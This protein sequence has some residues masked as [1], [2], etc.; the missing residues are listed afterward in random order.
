MS[1]FYERIN[2]LSQKR[3]VLL[4]MELQSRL[5][6]LESGPAA[7]TAGGHDIAVIG[8]GCRFPGGANSPETFWQLLQEGRDAVTEIPR[9]RWDIDAYYD[10]DVEAEGK[11][12]TRWGGFMND[13]DQFDPALFGIT[14]RE[15][16]TMDPQQRIVLEV[17]WEALERAGYA[18][19]KL[20][21]SSTG[22]FIG[23][24]NG[25]YGH[26]LMTTELET[27][28]MYMATGAAHSVI[29]GRVAYVL[30]LQ[31]PA[32]SVDTACSSSLVA[33]HYAIK[34]LRTGDCRMALAGGVNAIL[35]PDTTV[36]LS[37]AKMM[38]TEGRCKAFAADADGFVR[39]EGCGI[40]VLKRLKDAEADGDPILAVIRGTAINQDG[41][42]NGLTAPNG[43]SQVAVVRA[44]LADAG[45]Q[46]AEVGYV[47][48]HGTGT[49]LGDPIEAQALGA[50]Y[51]AGHTREN[52]LMIGSVK[53]N[54]GHMESAAGVGG[55]MKLILA[56]QYGEIPPHLHLRE[57]SPHIAWDELPITIPTTRSAWHGRR[58][59]AVSSFGFS[60]TNVHIIAEAYTPTPSPLRGALSGKEQH[61]L[62][63]SA[64]TATA[65]RAL[66]GRYANFL[67]Q[68]P[69]DAF[70][71]VAY[72]ANTTRASLSQRLALVAA[73]SAQARQKLESY[74][75]DPQGGEV[76]TAAQP[77]ARP[78]EVA[79][80]FTGHG[81][82]FAGMGRKLYETQPA[83]R[84]VIDR[85]SALAADM[86]PRPLIEA[87]YPPA[88]E[89]NHLLDT[90]TYGQ[91]VIFALQ[92]ALA[93]LWR[94]WGIQPA[95]VTGHSLGEYAAA[96]AAGILSLEDG[97]KLVCTRGRL[98]DNLPQSG[99]MAS[100]F[101]TEEEVQAIIQPRAGEVSIAVIN[102]PTNIVISGVP[103][104]VEAALAA[105]EAQGIKTR[106]LAIAAGAHSPLVE[107]MRAEFMRV[108]STVAFHAPR[109]D[110]VSCT[111]GQPVTAAEV[112]TPEYWWRH[113]R[114]PVQF[115]RVMQTLQAR[116]LAVFVEIGPHPVLLSIGQRVLPS[117]YG[118]WIPSLREKTDDTLQMLEALGML[119][120]AG[121]NIHWPGVYATTARSTLLLPTYAFD[122]QRYWFTA[123]ARPAG[124]GAAGMGTIAPL[125]GARIQSPVLDD[126][127][128]ETQLSATWPA[129]LDH[130][131]IFGTSI[132][133][134]PAYIEMATRAAE[135]FFGAGYYRVSNLAI[136]EAMILPEDGLRTAQ[137]ILTPEGESGARFKIVSQEPGGQWRTHATGEVARQPA[138]MPTQDDPSANLRQVEAARARCAE[139][140]D[141]ET[142]YANV[143]TLG[144][145]FGESFRGLRHIWRRD[146]EAVGRVELPA[147]L[148]GDPKNYRFHPALLDACFHLIGAP[149]PGGK[150]D[151]AFLL[152]GLEHFRLYRT[153]PTVLWNHTVLANAGEQAGETFTGDV[154]LYAEDGALVAEALGLQ[155]KRAS[156]ELL[157]RAV[158]PRFDEWLYRV[159]WQPRP[160]PLGQSKR[161]PAAW[162]LIGGD[163]LADA[164]MVQLQQAGENVTR[165]A[166]G[167]TPPTGAD[168]LYLAGVEA[169]EDD[170]LERSV[171][172]CAGLLD[173]A[174][175]EQTGRLWAAT[176]G[177]QPVSGAPAQPA[178]AALW[179]LGRVIA[180][181]LP[182]AW[183]GLI[184]LDPAQPPAE[185]ARLLVEEIRAGDSEDQVAYRAGQRSVARLARAARPSK[186]AYVFQPDAAYLITGGLG[187]IGMAIAR[188][189]ADHGARHIVLIGRHG[190]P[191]R[192][193]WDSLPAG[194]QQA[195][196]AATIRAIE[197][198]SGASLEALAVDASDPSALNALLASFGS[199]RP[200]LKGI[201]HAAAVLGN[202]GVNELSA[203][204]L[205]AMFTPKV[206]GAVNL[207]AAARGLDLDFL[208]L[209]SSTTALWGS[210]QMGHYA[211]ANTFL[212]SYA[213][214]LR[215]E[216][217]PALSINWGT[218]E[219]MRVASQADQQRVA[220]FGLEQMPVE[221]AM[222]ALSALIPSGEAQMT[223]AAVDW[224][225][226]KTAYEARRAR[227]LLEGLESRKAAAKT[228]AA[229][230]VSLAEQ[231]QAVKPEE[232]RAFITETV[233]QHVARVISAP[234]PAALNL[235]Q[236]LFE[237]GLDSLMSV[238]LKGRL[239]S[240][241]GKPLPSTLTFNYPTIADLARYLDESVLAPAAA[242]A[243]SSTPA[244]QPAA[245][246]A[247]QAAPT[248][249]VDDLSED[250]LAALLASKLKKLK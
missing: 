61:V 31:G 123:A 243:Q 9:S 187:G 13:V 76:I 133:P 35:S 227:P 18:P 157:M 27:V 209:F 124:P 212:D 151:N 109:I 145:E 179:G 194:N 225:T 168:V 25:D 176:R 10:P 131:R 4:A 137:I 250:D 165:L 95:V 140:I 50:S 162:A 175:L 178:A 2:N 181:E 74:L 196:Q 102:A 86:L 43:P 141:G 97:L 75:D 129:Y 57:L 99:S 117:G 200:P 36:T 246:E 70:G 150:V 12:A 62:C 111:T 66:A 208:A 45:M 235:T 15:A 217:L 186:P 204:D 49:S 29:S 51:G 23:A 156:R 106:R 230:S 213:H 147:N 63:L 39:S 160:L 68:Q 112:G 193:Q 91:P 144:L 58:V 195:Q 120:T 108:L 136:L 247:E 244:A 60:G 6:A 38:A 20:T 107:P 103:D 241:V 245:E 163:A 96:V 146:G 152:I 53:T 101:A 228:P 134:S 119:Y 198:D 139:E 92:V 203:A 189:L 83:Y 80:L 30:G 126:V 180:L 11:M 182:D 121:A 73:S 19:D 77:A 226:L 128:Y 143:A 233:R 37:K 64:K 158:K 110:L 210:S 231:L 118:T 240:S 125:L 1:D 222:T 159:E 98:M 65:L 190:L 16:A 177:A 17:S 169:G 34:S 207:A 28:D 93:E 44:A 116:G 138:E 5:E 81:A 249:D 94:A 87:L 197:A 3:L 174:R 238:E 170:L 40:L 173:A 21:G 47:E 220:Q 191:A 105:C 41:R 214:A 215:A 218:W 211:A 237:M 52:P 135:D 113:Q 82:Q 32:I 42:S 7:P 24:C 48:T 59:G 26:M 201:F 71:E 223:V 239:E 155:L 84:D 130:H 229:R 166:A 206:Q 85:C 104:A 188:W 185:Q 202:C 100:V 14:P 248:P 183:G 89:E 221:A 56:L 172:L 171:E 161:S 242:P 236:G 90:M 78:P 8:M 148:A 184:D 33:I 164:V 115:A 22:V 67:A 205:R 142:Y 153:P 88:G 219:V 192:E 114:Q 54:L 46:P 149:L 232:R 127:V 69:D 72:A 132:A 122:H 154:R 216:G 199:E 55:L 167:Q 234:D 224:S 79:F